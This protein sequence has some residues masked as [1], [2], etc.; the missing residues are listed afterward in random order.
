MKDDISSK[1]LV[2]DYPCIWRYKVIVAAASDIK[3]IIKRVLNEREYAIK[4]SNQ[5][6]AYISYNL[7]LTVQSGED[8]EAVFRALEKDTDVKFIL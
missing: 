1:E 5:K 6:G 7:E 2:I 8:R 4:S 3:A